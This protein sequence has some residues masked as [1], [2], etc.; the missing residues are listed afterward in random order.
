MLPGPFFI[1]R[2]K[3]RFRRA[4]K[5]R[6]PGEH[7]STQSSGLN[8]SVVLGVSVAFWI[9]MCGIADSDIGAMIGFIL[10]FGLAI[11]VAPLVVLGPVG[12]LVGLAAIA[13]YI[14]AIRKK[15][16]YWAPMMLV[17]VI[18]FI[19]FASKALQALDRAWP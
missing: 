1:Y 18:G 8:S 13:A 16:S 9:V 15:V 17:H 12:P 10:A 5:V 14:A 11:V 6:H 7:M 3:G 2:F 4:A 19:V